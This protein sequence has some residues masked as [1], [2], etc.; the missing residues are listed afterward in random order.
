MNIVE[1]KFDILV[2]QLVA[3]IGPIKH[4][5]ILFSTAFIIIALPFLYFKINLVKHN[6]REQS[7]L[8]KFT[9]A[10]SNIIVVIVKS[11]HRKYSRW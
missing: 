6:A 5:L 1:G 10:H 11:I 3:A 8:W 7:K 9:I 2:K 4:E